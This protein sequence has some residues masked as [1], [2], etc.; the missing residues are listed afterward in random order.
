MCRFF[1]IDQVWL[2]PT[3]T[4]MEKKRIGLVV[5]IFINLAS[6]NTGPEGGGCWNWFEILILQYMLLLLSPTSNIFYIFLSE[7]FP[8]FSRLLHHICLLSDSF[9]ANRVE[10]ALC[11]VLGLL[12]S[13]ILSSWFCWHFFAS[14]RNYS[15]LQKNW[16]KTE[17]KNMIINRD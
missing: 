3:S 6:H 7:F 13:A 12:F 11:I 10:V 8:N 1:S 15:Y 16:S 4:R 14:F 5:N 2:L 9:F 17:L